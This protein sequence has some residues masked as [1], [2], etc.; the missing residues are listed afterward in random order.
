MGNETCTECAGVG[1][2]IAELKCSSCKGNGTFLSRLDCNKCKATGKLTKEFTSMSASNIQFC[3]SCGGSSTPDD[4]CTVCGGTG[5]LNNVQKKT[6]E[7]KCDWCNGRG[8]TNK[9]EDCHARGTVETKINC[10]KCE[11]KGKHKK[12]H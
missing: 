4:P 6:R 10:S 3:S 11:G 7:I 9:C 8:Q 2:Q 5:R 12:G 1:Q